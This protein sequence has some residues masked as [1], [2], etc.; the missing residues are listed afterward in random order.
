[1][2]AQA[3]KSLGV[4]GEDLAGVHPG[5]EWLDD[6]AM[7][8]T[9]KSGRRALVIGGGNVAIDAARTLFREDCEV[10]VAYRRSKADM[11]AN[12]VELA[13][14]E[15]EGIR[16]EYMLQPIEMLGEK[17]HVKAVRFK[18]MKAGGIDSS[19]RPKPVE[20]DRIVDIPCDDVYIAVGEKVDSKFLSGAGVTT[21]SDGRVFADALSGKVAGT[22]WAIGDAVTGPA[23]AA[24][25]MGLGKRA[26][27]AIDAELMNRDAFGALFRNFGYSM[28]VPPEPAKAC[29]SCSQKVPPEQRRGNFQEI[30]LGYSGEQALMEAAR[31]LRCDIRA[32]ARS[33]WR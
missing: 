15:E 4:P 12:A 29:M 11:P 3:D 24:E 23:T 22:I 33:P 27:R 21:A 26:A 32:D 16:F 31:C 6:F 30:T 8:K 5:Y 7:G 17:G 13:G 18:V 9:E 2:G 25:A 19:G 28:D 20:T 1:V 14:A 10:T